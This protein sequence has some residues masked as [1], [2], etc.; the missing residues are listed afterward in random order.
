MVIVP[1]QEGIVR[2]LSRISIHGA[3]YVDVV[4]V[5][6]A[7]PDDPSAHLTARLGPEAVLGDVGVGDRVRIEGFLRMITRIEKVG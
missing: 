5:D 4:I 2:A 7:A 3:E 1:G 6:P